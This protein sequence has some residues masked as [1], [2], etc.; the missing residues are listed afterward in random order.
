MKT[1]DDVIY[2][3]FGISQS[4]PDTTPMDKGECKQAMDMWLREFNQ[5]VIE[6][7]KKHVAT[8]TECETQLKSVNKIFAD[9]IVIA[10]EAIEVG[11]NK[12][13]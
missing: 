7:N 8:I 3:V 11:K 6:E 2:D 10:H 12:V 9:I 1:K 4:A 13:I 5:K